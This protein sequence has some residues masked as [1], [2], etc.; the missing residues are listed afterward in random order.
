MSFEGDRG[1]GQPVTRQASIGG[2]LAGAAASSLVPTARPQYRPEFESWN[3]RR[4]YNL[5]KNLGSGA[6]GKVAEAKNM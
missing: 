1:G 5:V 6:Y 4:K 3:V 2:F